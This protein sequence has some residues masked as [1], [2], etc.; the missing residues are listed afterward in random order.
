MRITTNPLNMNYCDPDDCVTSSFSN[1]SHIE[2]PSRPPEGANRVSTTPLDTSTYCKSKGV[3]ARNS[4]L[5]DSSL[6]G[7]NDDLQI[8]NKP[9]PPPPLPPHGVVQPPKSKQECIEEYRPPVPPHR[10][11]GVTTHT[12]VEGSPRRHHHHH[13]HR[14]SRPGENGRKLEKN[15]QDFNKSSQQDDDGLLID[16]DSRDDGQA[17]AVKRSVFEFDDEPMVEESPKNETPSPKAEING[18]KMRHKPYGNA[19]ASGNAN[20]SSNNDE[21]VQFV[22]FPNSPNF[23]KNGEEII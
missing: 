2:L 10:N 21:D 18:V 9:T 12:P 19:C 14:N 5:V 7:V 13:H 1:P 15:Y 11:I 20:A 22:Q 6:S 16:L 3:T 23:N 4:N 17:E 8:W